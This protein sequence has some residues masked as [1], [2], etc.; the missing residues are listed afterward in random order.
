[1]GEEVHGIDWFREHGFMLREFSQLDWYLYPQLKKQGLRFE[2]PYQ[3]RI[4]RHGAQLAHRLHEIGIEWWDKQLEE[5]EALPGYKRFPDIWTHYASEVGRD[6]AE[7]PFW[8]LTARSMQY[9][10]GANVGL[11]LIHEVAQNVVGHDGIIV[12]R[13]AARRLGIA[14][15]DPVVLES[16]SGK[17]HGRATL[18]EGIRPDT[19]LLVGQFDHWATPYAKD[20]G[21]GSL[22]SRDA[23]GAVAHR[24]HGQR[25]G[26]DPGVAAQGRAAVKRRR[27]GACDDALRHGDR[28]QPLRRVPDLHHRLQARQRYA[29]RRAVAPRTRRRVRHASRTSSACSSSPAASIVPSRPACRC[30]RPAPPASAPTAW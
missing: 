9:A 8:A 27:E 1:M 25:R 2:L 15:G 20:L 3:E 28:P 11:P 13:T 19:V 18:R 21:L 14:D 22:N 24:C 17:T 26:P 5:Y 12:N 7:F 29:A 16:A 23:A 6:P 4:K 10:W 30:A